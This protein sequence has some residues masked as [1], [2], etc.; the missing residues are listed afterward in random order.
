MQFAR[1]VWHLL[2]AIKDGLVLLLLLLFFA[3]LY[4]V[5]TAR[6]SSASLKDGALLLKLDGAVVEEPSDQDP[7]KLIAGVEAPLKQYRVRDV[8]RSLELAASDDHI[9]VVVLDL[10]QFTGGGL[11]HM[12]EIGA[13]MDKVRA[14]KKPVLI[15]ATA[16]IDDGVMLA[17]HASEV[18][19]HPMGGAFVMGP[20]GTMP[21][22]GKLL[23]NYAV[24]VHVFKVGTFKDYVEPYERND[25]S[26]P[27]RE[28]RTA[29]YAA[30]WEDWKANVAKARPKAQIERITKD[31]AG[32]FVQAKGDGAQAALNAGLIDKIGDNVA[33]GERV[34]A[35]AGPGDNKDKPGSYAFSKPDALLA[36]HP[37]D[38]GGK[39]VAVVTVAGEIVDGKAGPGS[40]G[41]DR[42]AALI[43]KANADDAPALVLRVDSPGGS[44]LASE[45]IRGA[46]NRFKA[47]KDGKA[48]PVVVSMAN[49]AA[50]GGYWVSTPAQ[51]IFAEPGTVTGSIG[52][53]ALMPSFEDTLA[54]YGVTSDG[55]RTT[56]LSGQPDLIGG[57]TPEA[58]KMLQVN[59][60]NGYA[61][62]IGLVGQSRGKAPEEVDAMAQGRVWDGGTARQ[63]GLVDEFGGLPEALAYAAKA[64]KLET[65]HP[66][67]YGTEPKGL[68]GLL[69]KLMGGD[70]DDDAAS[71]SQGRDLAGLMALRQQD[72]LA[73]A[74]AGLA[75]LGSVQGMQAYCLDCTIAAPVPLVAR[76]D[77]WLLNLAGVLGMR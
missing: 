40:A 22:Y 31:P 14:A 49:L 74:V 15:Y 68:G 37:L 30:M 72:G 51:R 58:E 55:V 8:V 35:L 44:V 24:K 67:Y 48:R 5:L 53:F 57:L 25:A 33:F 26:A 19:A 54:R 10:S 21:Y 71:G 59:I 56:P 3:G 13:A 32:W 41:G 63:K 60:E 2:V 9:K 29:L 42:I 34:R 50:S 62:F 18:W 7:L 27:S 75:R 64:A 12:E 16:Y 6:P 17:A 73:R 38:E 46:L 61:R 23:Q 52:I 65:W 70:D 39:A 45:Q 77:N 69:E 1:K 20:G 76:K 4:N 36:A 47:P 11:V 28:A 43:D 66:K